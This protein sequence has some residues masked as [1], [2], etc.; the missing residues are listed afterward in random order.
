M[1]D[2]F[3]ALRSIRSPLGEL[4]PERAARMRAR[5]LA[6][7][8]GED[9][10]GGSVLTDAGARGTDGR[11][12]TVLELVP[13]AD[14]ARRAPSA[15]DPGEPTWRPASSGSGSGR[16]PFLLVAA[17][18]IVAVLIGVAIARGGEGTDVVADRP[19][20]TTVADLAADARRTIDRPVA[21]GE[22]AHLRYREADPL[23]EASGS[24]PYAVRSREI[25]S[26]STGVGRDRLSVT[27]V[28]DQGRTV[29]TL[30]PEREVD[31]PR[32]APAFGSFG[33]ATLRDLPSDPDELRSVLRSGTFGPTDDEAVAHLVAEL[34][35]LDATPPMVRAAALTLLADDGATLRE[36]VV[37]RAGNRGIGIV[38]GRDDGAATVYV[39]TPDGSL[40]GAY[41]IEPGSP[42]DPSAASWWM[43]VE[44]QDRVTALE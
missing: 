6:G 17:A 38:A 28:D 27:V 4:D 24:A 9:H 5:A 1:A 7:A 35:M 18:A 13:S 14:G 16:R 15:P 30:E 39:V 22:Y 31:Y 44:Q 41:D 40:L 12:A 36:D 3:D 34:L 21:P 2:D 11:D 10:A 32:D 23:D 37:D 20:P 43:T 26:T 8:L 29:E 33:Y 19:A 25:W 42:I